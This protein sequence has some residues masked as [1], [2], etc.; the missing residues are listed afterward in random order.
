[1]YNLKNKKIL[2][3]LK[4]QNLGIGSFKRAEK[5][6]KIFK[7]SDLNLYENLSLNLD[8]NTVEIVIYDKFIDFKIFNKF[9]KKNIPQYLITHPI[10]LEKLKQK[11]LKKIIKFLKGLIVP[12]PEDTEIIN[13]FKN[14]SCN[15]YFVDFTEIV[16]EKNII[17]EELS[18]Y[19]INEKYIIAVS[20]GGGWKNS[21]KLYSYVFNNYPDIL[22]IFIY[23]SL[24]KEKT[25][26]T[27]SSSSLIELYNLSNPK[28]LMAGAEMIFCRGG[29]NTL[30]EICNY[31]IPIFCSPEETLFSGEIF[32]LNFF[33]KKNSY[34]NFIH[35]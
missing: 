6:K 25:F 5:F 30:S 10:F 14:F 24:Y 33:M 12:F 7:L 9:L 31:K 19:K 4:N 8:L 27:P 28:V 1:M 2:Y 17:K 23:G 29:L 3:V 34:I 15:L 20:G 35:I 22:K 18:K 26:F 16:P 13:L 21:E 11:P 32:N